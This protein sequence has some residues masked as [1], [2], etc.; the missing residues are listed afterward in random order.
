MAAGDAKGKLAQIIASAGVIDGRFDGLT[1]AIVGGQFSIAFFAREIATGKPV[2]LKFLDPG[3]NRDYREQ[4]FHREVEILGRLR[5]RENIVQIAGEPGVLQLE[6]THPATGVSMPIPCHYVAMERAKQDFAAYLMAHRRSPVLHRRLDV[7]YDAAKG[8]GR[9]HREGYCHRD[10]KPD[11][12]LLFRGGLGKLGDFGTGRSLV[13]A[14]LRPDYRWPVGAFQ[15]AAPEMLCGGWNRRELFQGAD[16]F[17]L[18][19]ILFEAVTGLNLYVAVGLQ[20]DDLLSMIEYFG[21]LPEDS[22][23]R[24]YQSVVSDIAG[25]YPLPS[26]RDFVGSEPC[27]AEASE[28]TLRALDSLVRALCHF[29]YRRRSPGFSET[30]RGLDIAR[31]HALIDDRRRAHR[32]MRQPR[33][34]GAAGR[35]VAGAEHD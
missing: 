4:G 23:L 21:H 14:P 22:R 12:V 15:N 6:L 29:D 30:L 28:E 25:E 18:G 1:P 31:G 3:Y 32:M 16:W 26:V 5:G 20:Q 34:A 24:H 9:L 10:L 7:V 8:V 27:L 19:A 11:N 17:S 33:R 2:F 35:T 13:G